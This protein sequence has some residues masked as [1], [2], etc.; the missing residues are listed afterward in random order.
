MIEYCC[1]IMKEQLEMK[2]P[3]HPDLSDCPD[4][5]IYKSKQK[6]YY[7]IRVHDG[8][9]SSVAINFCPWCGSSLSK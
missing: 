1:I 4:S 3:D 9:S 7:G 6:N 5:L 2:C 8:G